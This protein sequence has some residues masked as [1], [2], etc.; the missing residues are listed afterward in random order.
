MSKLKK[1]KRENK[2]ALVKTRAFLSDPIR[3]RT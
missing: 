1:E 2:K 3:I